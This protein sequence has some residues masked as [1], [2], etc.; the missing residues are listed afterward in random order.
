MLKSVKKI[1]EFK[2]PM[3]C[4]SLCSYNGGKARLYNYIAF[5]IYKLGAKTFAELCA[6]SAVVSLNV[7]VKHKVLNDVNIMLAVV[8]K[9]LSTPDT[10]NKVLSRLKHAVYS[11]KTFEDAQTYWSE[12]GGRPLSFFEGQELCEAAYHSLILLNFSRTGSSITKTFINTKSQKGDFRLFQ[13]RLINYYNKLTGAEVLNESILT[14]LR[15]WSENPDDIPENTVIYIDPPYLPSKKRGVKSNGSYTDG[16]TKFDF[17]EEAHKEMLTYVDRLPR[18]KCKV[19]I[20]GYDDASGV[21]DTLLSRE[22]FGEWSKIFVK[23]LVVMS[24]DGR[25]YKDRKRPTE[26]EYFFTNFWL[27]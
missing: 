27:N 12:N 25:K 18:E 23:E 14:I 6:G 17:G 21:Y 26:D 16:T 4:C 24:G 7:K 11:Q 10:A 8:Y 9:A 3:P 13:K 5:L 15:E 20:S 2:I 1:H 22:D 19:I